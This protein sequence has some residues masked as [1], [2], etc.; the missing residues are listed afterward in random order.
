[1]ISR[2]TLESEGVYRF[3]LASRPKWWFGIPSVGLCP[4]RTAPCYPE[5]AVNHTTGEQNPGAGLCA[6][7]NANCGCL[8]P[9]EKCEG[10]GVST[11]LYRASVQQ[12]GGASRVLGVLP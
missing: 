7:P 5:P 10:K 4:S 1:P 3:V 11:L 6:W 12:H 8:Y 2:S 9:S